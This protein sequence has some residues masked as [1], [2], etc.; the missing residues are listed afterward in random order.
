MEEI[1]SDEVTTP[2]LLTLNSVLDMFKDGVL[3]DV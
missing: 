3:S 1:K 2:S